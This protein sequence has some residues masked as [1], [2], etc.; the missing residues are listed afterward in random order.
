MHVEPRSKSSIIKNKQVFLRQ[1]QVFKFLR[2]IPKYL[3]DK[4]LY[5]WS[6]YQRKVLVQLENN[7][8]TSNCNCLNMLNYSKTNCRQ[9]HSNYHVLEHGQWQR[10]ENSE[11]NYLY[12]SNISTIHLMFQKDPY[13]VWELLKIKTI[14]IYRNK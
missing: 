8:V 14:I 1:I 3:V 13:K 2:L 5:Y 12:C 10:C 9:I 11:Q 6:K 7:T 4:V